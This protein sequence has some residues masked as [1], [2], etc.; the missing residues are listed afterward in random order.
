MRLHL[1][2][3]RPILNPQPCRYFSGP[4][5]TLE[6]ER[7]RGQRNEALIFFFPGAEL[8]IDRCIKLFERFTLFS[9]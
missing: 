9:T 2:V 4:I 3:D 5:Q 1:A 7:S 6:Q 8:Q